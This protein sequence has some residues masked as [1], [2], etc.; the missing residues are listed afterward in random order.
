MTAKGEMVPP[1]L[2]D[3]ER[4]HILD[5]VIAGYERRGW[6]VVLRLAARAELAGPRGES[7]YLEVEATGIFI[8]RLQPKRSAILRAG[9]RM[10][11]WEWAAAREWVV[12]S[13]AVVSAAVFILD[14]SHGTLGP[15]TL[16]A[17]LL[18]GG[19]SMWMWA[20]PGR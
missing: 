19:C 6:K 8:D 17:W 15:L 12:V 5:E 14:V 11:V 18:A 9:R 2:T 7:R 10:M 4:Q 13:V 3:E 1:E 16:A 20:H